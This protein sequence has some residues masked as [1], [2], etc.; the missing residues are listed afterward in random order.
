MALFCMIANLFNVCLIEDRWI[1]TSETAF[2]LLVYC[3]G[4]K[5]YL[6]GSS[7]KFV[8]RK[9]EYSNSFWNNSSLFLYQ[10]STSDSFLNITFN[11][12]SKTVSL[13][14]S[15]FVILKFIS[16]SCTLNESFIPTNELVILCIGYLKN[17]DLLKFA[18][19]PNWTL[20][21]M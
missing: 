14:F 20:F 10:N 21:I 16:L 11:V 15:C 8:V 12:E 5:K 13:S 9:Q 19:L 2:N 6:E 18:N 1:L 3:F 17:I 7:H 4:G